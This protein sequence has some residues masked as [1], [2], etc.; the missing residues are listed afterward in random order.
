MRKDLGTGSEEGDV[1]HVGYMTAFQNPENGLDDHVVYSH[2]LDLALLAAEL[3]FDSIWA[4]EHHFTDYTMSPD[5]LQ[6]L[7]WIAARTERVK[8]GTAVLVLPWHDPMRLAEQITMLD[9][10]SGGRMILG[11]GRGLARVEYE[12]F[13]VD[14]NTSRQLFIESAQ[15]LLEGLERGWLEF[16]GELLQ[17]TRRE[18]RPKPRR[19]FRGRTYAA[20]VSPESMP[21]MAQLGVGVLVIPQKPWA[22]VEDDFATYR[23]VYQDVNGVDA[24]PPLCGGFLFVDENADRAEEL[25]H[26]YIGGYYGTV[27]K[28]YELASSPHKGV[29]GYEF[30]TNVSRYIDRHGTESAANDFVGLAP[31]GT[32][33]QVLEKLSFIR[34]TIGAA[35][36]MPA[37]SY[38][39][40]PYEEAE[41]NIRLFAKEVLP[42]L[43]RW[44]AEPLPEPDALVH[45]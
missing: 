43:R 13:G 38:A 4:I 18:I 45:A 16:D 26:R 42:E 20:A 30:Y 12:G 37:F 7:S 14:M 27:M 32:P 15:A 21:I 11:I 6:L 34:N 44:E 9:T 31:W 25:A 40:M 28:H 36:F 17:Q 39:G 23:A 10:L 3:E 19:S 35:G 5:P 8:L 29:K 24:P 33:D 22:M 1:M 41:R 2:E